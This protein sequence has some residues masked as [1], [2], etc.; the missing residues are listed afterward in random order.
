[1]KGIKIS[2]QSLGNELSKQNIQ[3]IITSD[4][5]K[6][7]LTEIAI[8]FRAETVLNSKTGELEYDFSEMQRELRTAANLRAKRGG[9]NSPGEIVFDTQEP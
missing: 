4:E 5:L 9:N 8:D 6:K 7:I 3:E 2:L 1:M